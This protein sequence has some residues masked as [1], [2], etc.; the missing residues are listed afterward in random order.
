M[1]SARSCGSNTVSHCRRSD[2]RQR[3]GLL[4]SQLLLPKMSPLHRAEVAEW[5]TRGI[6]NPVSSRVCGFDSHL[7]H[8]SSQT[9]S[10]TRKRAQNPAICGVFAFLAEEI[11]QR[12]NSRRTNAQPLSGLLHGSQVFGPGLVREIQRGILPCQSPSSSHALG[13]DVA[14]RPTDSPRWS[15]RE[16]KDACSGSR[17]AWGRSGELAFEPRPTTRRSGRVA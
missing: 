4:A 6:Q 12:R 3:R 7:R 16:A 11:R 1:T 2:Q 17:S 15:G 8:S 5:Q 9:L 13:E 10:T 14:E